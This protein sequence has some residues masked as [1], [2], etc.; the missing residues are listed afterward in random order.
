MRRRPSAGTGDVFG[1]K[2]LN[3]GHFF[4]Q[5]KYTSTDYETD[6]TNMS[7]KDKSTIVKHIFDVAWTRAFDWKTGGVQEG[8]ENLET[9]YDVTKH[10]PTKEEFL[11]SI[12][13]DEEGDA[14]PYAHLADWSDI[15]DAREF[16]NDPSHAHITNKGIG[17]LIEV[18]H[19]TTA[20]LQGFMETNKFHLDTFTDDSNRDKILEALTL[21]Y[22]KRGAEDTPEERETRRVAEDER[23]ARTRSE[24]SAEKTLQRVVTGNGNPPP[25]WAVSPNNESLSLFILEEVARYLASIPGAEFLTKVDVSDDVTTPFQ[26]AMDKLYK[27]VIYQTLKL[28]PE[29]TAL[30]NTSFSDPNIGGKEIVRMIINSPEQKAD[31]FER[32]KVLN[33]NWANFDIHDGETCATAFAR[34]IKIRRGLANYNITYS[35]NAAIMLIVNAFAGAVGHVLADMCQEALVANHTGDEMIYETTR[36][37]MISRDKISTSISVAHTKRAR[38][39]TAVSSAADNKKS[40]LRNNARIPPGHFAEA[41]GKVDPLLKQGNLAAAAK[42]LEEYNLTHIQMYKGCV[43]GTE[44]PRS[45]YKGLGAGAGGGGAGR[46]KPVGVCYAWQ[47]GECQRGNSC[48]FAHS[49]G[50]P[51]NNSSYGANKQK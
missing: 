8:M 11:T 23:K 39:V 15:D 48:K 50:D 17:I 12:Q 19:L 29:I 5:P 13:F 7:N 51:P 49:N 33:T 22:K 10:I 35:D 27:E 30:F 25:E 14:N 45:E 38:A 37:T 26:K 6:T 43:N 31:D 28:H 18:F 2:A 40:K 20:S 36:D 42:V 21:G 4:I 3:L 32:L 9:N 1:A 44:R 46:E 34:L 41:M 16:L 24:E 47:R